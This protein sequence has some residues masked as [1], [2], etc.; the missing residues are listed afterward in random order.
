MRGWTGTGDEDLAGKVFS[1]CKAVAVR[2][3]RVHSGKS[4]L[5]G[6]GPGAHLANGE[7]GN[8]VDKWAGVR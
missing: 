7:A 5:L 3:G 6:E 1:R 2:A 8:E 4:S